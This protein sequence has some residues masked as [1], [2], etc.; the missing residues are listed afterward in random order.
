MSRE[1]LQ[2]IVL[3]EGENLSE[4]RQVLADREV[5]IELS[6]G[7]VSGK[8]AHAH[9]VDSFEQHCSQELVR[10][11]GRQNPPLCRFETLG[12]ITQE[13]TEILDLGIV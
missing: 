1:S 12:K 11:S 6:V 8:C 7:I 3:E 4:K 10:L 9:R 2:S 13:R 5:H